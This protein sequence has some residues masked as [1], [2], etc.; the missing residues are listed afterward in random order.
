MPPYLYALIGALMF[1]IAHGMHFTVSPTPVGIERDHVQ[2][3]NAR[4][5]AAE[6]DNAWTHNDIR[7]AGIGY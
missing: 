6:H 3:A 5:A 7:I 1:A 2:I 4:V